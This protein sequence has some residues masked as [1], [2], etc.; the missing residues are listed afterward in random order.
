MLKIIVPGNEIYNQ[1]TEMFTTNQDLV[2]ELEHSLISLSKWESIYE[3][4]FLSSGKKAPEEILGYVYAM[5]LTENIDESVMFRLSQDNIEQINRYVESKHSA[6][7]FGNMPE[8]KGRGETITSELIYYWMV[9]FNIPFECQ[10]WHLNRLFALIRI[11]N[12]KNSKPKKMSRN[13]L[14]ARNRELNEQRRRTLNT[15]G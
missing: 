10:F 15:S 7:T 1:E 3:K 6:T 13:E 11:C 12:I 8:R 5:L 2:L 14:A 9:A 4:P